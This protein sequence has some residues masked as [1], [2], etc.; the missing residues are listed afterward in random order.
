MAASVLLKRSKDIE[1]H[2]FR[3]C[4]RGTPKRFISIKGIAEEIMGGWIHV[5]NVDGRTIGKF[6]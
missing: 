2:K 4:K 1:L 5:R 6:C 3:K